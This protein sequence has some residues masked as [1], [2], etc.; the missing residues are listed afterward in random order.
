MLSEEDSKDAIELYKK[1][2]FWD[3]CSAET[4]IHTDERKDAEF[5]RSFFGEWKSLKKE[6]AGMLAKMK[7]SWKQKTKKEEEEYLL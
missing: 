3:R 1:L 6:V 7:E 2:M 4:A 5:I